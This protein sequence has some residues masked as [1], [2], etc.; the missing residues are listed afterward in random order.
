VLGPKLPEVTTH[1]H[2]AQKIVRDR[3]RLDQERRGVC[4]SEKK[5]RPDAVNQVVSAI[6]SMGFE[7][8]DLMIESLLKW[9]GGGAQLGEVVSCCRGV[10][11]C[12]GCAS[13]TP[14]FVN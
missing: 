3:T 1:A 12:H 4:R 9:T 8:V 10:P 14:P 7:V 6:L 2:G 13:L 11:E 5:P